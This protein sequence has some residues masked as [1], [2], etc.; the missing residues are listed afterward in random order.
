[1]SLPNVADVLIVGAGSAGVSTAYY[2]VQAGITDVLIVDKH[3]SPTTSKSVNYKIMSDTFP[4]EVQIVIIS[5]YED[6]DTPLTHPS[7]CIR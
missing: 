7:K 3:V 2:L 5:S 6:G 4:T 1:M